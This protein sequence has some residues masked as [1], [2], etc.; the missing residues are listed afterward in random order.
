MGC[1]LACAFC[2][3]YTLSQPPRLGQPVAG[4]KIN[5]EELVQAALLNGAASISYTYSEP[6]VF[7]ELL[8]E[9]ADLA[10]AKGLKNI[11]VS[12]GFQSPQCLSALAPR[13][14]AANI[15]L[16]AMNQDEP[17]HKIIQDLATSDSWREAFPHPRIFYTLPPG[18]YVDLLAEIAADFTV[19]Q[20]TY[21][22]RL[23]SHQDI[24]EWYRGTG[25]RPYLDALPDARKPAFE[26][27]VLSRVVAAYP[28]QKNGEVIFRFPRFFFIAMGVE[29]GGE[30][31][32]AL[33]NRASFARLREIIRNYGE[34][35][36][37]GRIARAIVAAREEAAITTTGQLAKVVAAAYPAKW[38][39][40]AIIEDAKPGL[41]TA[42]QVI[43]E[44]DRR[45]A[46]GLAL[47]AMRP[48]DVLVI[49]GKGHGGGHP[50]LRTPG[51]VTRRRGVQGRRSGG[52]DAAVPGKG[53]GSRAVRR[54]PRRLRAGPGR[55][56]AVFLRTHPAGSR[57]PAFRRRQTGGHHP[58]VPGHGQLRPLSELQG[59]GS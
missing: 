47:A 57:H 59:A 41:H 13:I 52:P 48:E 23:R 44:P 55:K 21:F 26:E 25:L 38:R 42:R 14:D 5:P 18:R 49:A 19:W 43:I 8:C 40:M 39:A 46:I 29:D 31:A 4:E 12:N 53:G 22:H 3:N 54:Q 15:D 45:R 9:T 30:S 33:V 56:G 50:Q 10:H 20:T 1:N 7:F 36:Q 16:K 24:L 11:I 35:P 58:P 51:A 37:A 17:I 34:D 6:T 32:E 27:A 28:L 2:Q